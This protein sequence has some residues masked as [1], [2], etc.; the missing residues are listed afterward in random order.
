M[1]HLADT[2]INL[3]LKCAAKHV[4][5][6]VEKQGEGLFCLRLVEDTADGKKNPRKTHFFPNRSDQIGLEIRQFLRREFRTGDHAFYS[7]SAFSE[8]VA[9]AI[10]A[11]PGRLLHVDADSVALPPNGP[12]PSRIVQSSPGNYHFFY[13]LKAPVEPPIAQELSRGLTHLV[14]GDIGGHSSAK[15][16]R[17]P[18]T[19]NAKY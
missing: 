9:K 11:V 18:G 5:W 17:L 10:H 8:P 2:P 4:E 12:Q 1:R 3:D 19:I 13:V 15:L 16:L 14:G 6:L 7:V